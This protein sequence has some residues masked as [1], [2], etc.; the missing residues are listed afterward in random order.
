MVVHS[1]PLI[2]LAILTYNQ[3]KYIAEAIDGALSQCY[4]PLEIIISDDC[5]QDVT[6]QII[7]KKSC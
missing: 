2:T 5:S 7:K 6:Y 4:H 3:A 1:K